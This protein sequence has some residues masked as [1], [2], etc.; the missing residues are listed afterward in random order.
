MGVCG[1]IQAMSII[2]QYQMI[3]KNHIEKQAEYS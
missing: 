2:R 3:D 1:Q